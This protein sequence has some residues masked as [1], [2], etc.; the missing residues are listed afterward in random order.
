[1]IFINVWLITG[2]CMVDR[3]QGRDMWFSCITHKLIPAHFNHC[4]YITIQPGCNSGRVKKLY[5]FLL[6]KFTSLRLKLVSVDICTLSK[7]IIPNLLILYHQFL[8][9]WMLVWQDLPVYLLKIYFSKLMSIILQIWSN[10]AKHTELHSQ[11]WCWRW[12][13]WWRRG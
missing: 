6:C 7:K 12:R 5:F 1:M 8:I 3:R 2:K 4:T 11:P 9:F 13:W 10:A